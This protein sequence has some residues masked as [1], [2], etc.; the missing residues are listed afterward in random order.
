MGA[1]SPIMTTQI[2]EQLEMVRMQGR[3]NMLERNGVQRAAHDFDFDELVWF[4]DDTARDGWM[5]VLNKL[6]EFSTGQTSEERDAL[7]DRLAELD[8]EF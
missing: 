8:N 6:G 7:R 2:V 3:F 1:N 4:I 5:D